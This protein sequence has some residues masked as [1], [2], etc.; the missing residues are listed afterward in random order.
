VRPDKAKRVAAGAASQPETV[1]PGKAERVAARWLA[2]QTVRL[3][4]GKGV[5]AWVA[6]QVVTACP[7]KGD[8]V[9]AGAASQP[10]TVRTGKAERV[11]AGRL[12]SQ[13]Q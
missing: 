5:V 2:S 8:W 1:R 6:S 11:V 12:A 9:A 4:R 3:C 10:D 13:R 7:V